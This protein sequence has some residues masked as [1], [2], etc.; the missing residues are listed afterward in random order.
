M[1]LAFEAKNLLKLFHGQALISK[2]GEEFF[3]LFR[4]QH[5]EQRVVNIIGELGEKFKQLIH[6][7]PLLLPSHQGEQFSHILLRKIGSVVKGLVNIFRGDV[8]EFK[9]VADLCCRTMLIDVKLV[10]GRC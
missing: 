1:L 6:C 3:E 2:K 10:T 5:L 4:D 9:L 8:V 7:H